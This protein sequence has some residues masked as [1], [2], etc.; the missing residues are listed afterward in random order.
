M[1]RH[2]ALHSTLRL[3]YYT[4]R[5]NRQTARAALGVMGN[6]AVAAPDGEAGKFTPA[7]TQIDASKYEDQL[8]EK[9]QRIRSKFAAFH[10]PPLEV[11]RS[12]PAH[13]RCRAEF[14]VWHDGEDMY[15]LM[16]EKGGDGESK[17][18]RPEQRQV[19]VDQ[20]PVASRLLNELMALLRDHVK[21]EPALRRK[22]FQAN[23][24]TTL[25]GQSMISLIYHRTLDDEWREAARGL[26][27]AL[28]AAPSASAPT[29]IIGRSKGQK[30]C[31]DKDEVEEVLQVDGQQLRYIQVEAS[32]SQP[33]AGMC[34][35]M[36]SWARSVTVGSA[37]HD[38]LELYCGN[39]N[40]TVALAPNFRQ[41]V[42][43]EL[44]KPGVAAAK[45]NFELNGVSN[46][47]VARMSSEDFT[48]AWKEGRTMNRLKG[49]DLGTLELR[50]LLVDPPR[51][52]LD[53][54]TVQLLRDFDN[55]AYV[56]CNPDTLLANLEEV[57]DLFEIRRFAMFDQFPYTHHVETGVYLQRRQ[58]QGEE[59]QQQ[60]CTAGGQAAADT[61]TDAAADG[62][63]VKRKAEDDPQ[64]AEQQAK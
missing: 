64:Q 16:Y 40:F 25:S 3:A 61:A 15:F 27:R 38:L 60:Q 31:V 50:T 9:A 12:A 58:Q 13:Y 47:F 21:G 24:H 55:V 28:A 19:R 34:Q 32:F 52:G 54:Q 36:L 44:S 4:C 51:A 22:L 20:F 53:K 7:L 18:G 45:R 49:L 26:Q 14:R 8:V 63:G 17:G 11:F 30:V 1:F 59:Q 41:V 46:V 43:T 23:F 6:F 29:Q 57:K 42:A 35:N 2:P 62:K 10:P 56:S 37:A 48:S 33:N 39:G 5:H